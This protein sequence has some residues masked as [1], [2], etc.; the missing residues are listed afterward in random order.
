MASLGTRL[1]RTCEPQMRCRSSSRGTASEWPSPGFASDSSGREFWKAPRLGVCLP[2]A[3]R[4]IRGAMVQANRRV[5]PSRGLLF[6]EEPCAEFASPA[7]PRLTDFLSGKLFGRQQVNT[8][9]I[10]LADVVGNRLRAPKDTAQIIITHGIIPRCSCRTPSRTTSMVIA[11]RDCPTSCPNL[12]F[13]SE[14]PR[15]T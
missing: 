6:I 1:T 2:E 10:T 13:D 5:L 15:C 14:V 12:E 11:G 9:P 4:Q 7:N 3:P 8:L